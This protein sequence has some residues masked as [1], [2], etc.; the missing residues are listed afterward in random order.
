MVQVRVGR[1]ED[2]PWLLHECALAAWEHISPREQVGA[3]F[4]VVAQRVETVVRTALAQPGGT[5]LVAEAAGRP[6]GSIAY[7]VQP[8]PL[9]GQSE[10][11]VLHLRVDPAWRGQGIGRILIRAAE[12]HLRQA[13]AR[14]VGVVV[15]LHATEAL[16]FTTALGYWPERVLVARPLV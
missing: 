1:A 6:V 12:Q 8:N 10:G 15:G 13:G 16:R 9:T 5:L 14:G 2:L 4:P 3:H 11:L 7:H